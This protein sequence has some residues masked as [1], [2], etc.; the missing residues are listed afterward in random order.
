ML[1]FTLNIAV[2][3]LC[4]NEFDHYRKEK[5]PHPLFIEHGIDAIPFDH[6]DM[7]KWRN[8]RQGIGYV[9]EEKG[10][11]FYGAVDDVWVKPSDE[12]IIADVKAT[13]K[14]IFNWE[15]T[16]EKYD[17]ARGYQRQ[18]EMY[19]WMFRKNGFQVAN[20]AYLVYFNGLKNEPFFDQNLK[21]DLHV[22]RLECDTSWVEQKVLEATE[23]LKSNDYPQASS[24]CE[25]CN[26]LKER[27]NVSRPFY[28]KETDPI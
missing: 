13:A 21:F 9:D 18:L 24:A 16:F 19:Q 26:Y 6:P 27:W 8:Y 5:K 17:Y 20:E 28:S 14:N 7:D 25:N 23:L 12:L 15:E 2:D 3:N 22:I 4:K 11:N 10:Y 1:P